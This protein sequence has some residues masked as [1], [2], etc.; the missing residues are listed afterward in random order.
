ML[1]S[2]KYF[3]RYEAEKKI[4]GIKNNK[5][6]NEEQQERKTLIKRLQALGI[7]STSLFFIYKNIIK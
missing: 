5:K 6:Y 2:V 3:W 1:K 7:M 4:K